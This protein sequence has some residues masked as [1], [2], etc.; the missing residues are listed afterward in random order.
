[1][2]NKLSQNK[3]LENHFN[4]SPSSEMRIKFPCARRGS[5][6][7]GLRRAFIIKFFCV[8][9]VPGHRVED[10]RKCLSSSSPDTFVCPKRRKNGRQLMAARHVKG[11]DK[12]GRRP[13]RFPLNAHHPRRHLQA[14]KTGSGP[15]REQSAAEHNERR[16]RC[17]FMLL[18][19][20]NISLQH[21]I[22]FLLFR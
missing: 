6:M 14:P 15:A 16:S 18:G 19:H 20:H 17:G 11:S 4:R 9:N 1:M 10:E 7:V 2:E 8:Q 21:G 13:K 3:I 12:N 22:L 5:K